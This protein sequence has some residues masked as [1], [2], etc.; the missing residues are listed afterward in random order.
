MNPYYEQPSMQNIN[1]PQYSNMSSPNGMN[2]QPM[3]V[4]PQNQG[5]QPMQSPPVYQQPMQ[6]P[7]VYQQNGNPTNISPV[8]NNTVMAPPPQQQAINFNP[9]IQVVANN[10]NSNNN[11][12]NNNNTGGHSC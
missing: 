10:N 6:S 5:M 9:V 12:N 7:P 2:T 4:Q 8:F 1:Q 3:Y 11:F